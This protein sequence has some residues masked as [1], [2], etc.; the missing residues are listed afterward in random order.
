MAEWRIA[1]GAS[2]FDGLKAP[3]I[4]DFLALGFAMGV[5][6]DAKYLSILIPRLHGATALN[7][8]IKMA[9]DE[10][11]NAT[12][13]EPLTHVL[14]LDR[15]VMLTGEQAWQLLNQ[16]DPWHPAVFALGRNPQSR[17][18]S[19]WEWQDAEHRRLASP[20]ETPGLYRVR[21]AGLHAAAFDAD[22]FGQLRHPWFRW[23]PLAGSDP[24]SNVCQSMIA[25]LIPVYCDTRVVVRQVFPAEATS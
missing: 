24:E 25:Q 10:I 9:G 16:V 17:T 11:D 7:A 3:L 21:S 6:Q 13:R 12:V 4:R 23:Q 5:R 15:D 14:W 20:P 1:I 8:A 22:L 18:W 19:F 2:A